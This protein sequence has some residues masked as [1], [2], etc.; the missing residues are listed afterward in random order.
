MADRQEERVAHLESHLASIRDILAKYGDEDPPRAIRVIA[1][2]V[3][4]ALG[5]KKPG[6]A[7]LEELESAEPAAPVGFELHLRVDQPSW[8]RL[9][10]DPLGQ[11]QAPA[12]ET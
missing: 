4:F 11:V 6:L 7:I 1:Q 2:R 9:H 12:L 8:I 10:I 3:D 5:D